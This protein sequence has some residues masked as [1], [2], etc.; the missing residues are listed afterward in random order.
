[1]VQKNWNKLSFFE[2]MSNI[3][4]EVERLVSS[5]ERYKSGASSEDYAETYYYKVDQLIRMTIFD[6]KNASRGYRSLELLDELSEIRRY[7]NGEVPADYI[8]RYWKQYT[9]AIS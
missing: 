7:L 1:M 8:T 9:D 6:P 5:H 4:G 2:Q 3:D